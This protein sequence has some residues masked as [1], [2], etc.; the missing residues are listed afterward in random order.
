[1]GVK[2]SNNAKTTLSASV[3]TSATSVSV[4]S[5]SGFPSLS[6]GDYFYATMVQQSDDTALEIVKVTAVSGTT[7]TVSRAQDNTSATAFASGDKIELRASAGVFIDLFAEKAPIANPT[8]TGNLTIGSAEIS[9]TELEIL[10][11]AT[12]TTAELNKLDGTTATAA[13]LTYGKDLYDTGVTAAE[14]DYLDGV[15]SNIQTQISTKL[16]TPSGFARGSVIIGDSSGNPANLS[17]GANG[18]VLKS[19]GTDVTWAEDEK[20]TTTNFVKNAFTGDNTTTAFTLSQSPNSEDNL[21]VFIEGVFQ[22]QGDYALSGTTLT[23]DEAPATGRKIVAYHV[24]AAVSGANLNHDQFTA[25]GSAAFTLSI[26]PINENNTQVFIDGVYQQ[27]TDYSVSGTTL[28][29]DTAPASGAIVEVMT[30]TQTEI[31]V[32]TTGSVVTASIANDVNLN[33]NPT[34][35]TQSA[36]NNTTRIATTAFVETAVSN[37]IDSAPGTMNTLNEIAAALGDD[38][39]FTTTVN[40]AIAT[41]LPLAGGTMTGNL[42]VGGSGF[43]TT[44]INSTRTS[45]NIGGINFSA[46]GTNKAQIYGT[47]DGQLKLGTGGDGT[48]DSNL[49]LTLD[50]AGKVG[51]GTASP[52]QLLHV[53]GHA[54]ITSAY[55]LMFGDGGER[56]SGNNSTEILNFFTG[57]TERM[58]IDS[59]GKTLHT[60]ASQGSAFDASDNTTW[61]ALEIFQ[62]RGVT[63]SGSGI[64]FRSQSG[65]NP[66]G[67]VSVA[68]NTTGGIES[69][70]FITVAGN[71]GAERMRLHST[72]KLTVGSTPSASNGVIEANY[73]GNAFTLWLTTTA[74]NYLGFESTESGGQAWSFRTAGTGTYGSANGDL[75][76][77]NGTGGIFMRLDQS[78]ATVEGDFNDT[79]DIGLKKNIK[80]TTDGLA[81]LLKL[82]ARKFDWKDKDRRNN[83]NGFIAQ[84]VETVLPDEVIGDDYNEKKPE[85]GNKSINT[86]G[87]LAVAVKAIQEQQTIIDDLKARIETLEG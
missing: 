36:G 56:I 18:Y 4:A 34:T 72:G 58:R 42:V 54:A 45:G 11:G 79:S 60:V 86:S 55:S 85:H 41:K 37:L 48:V 1:V 3:S 52:S 35:T 14:F 81:E 6:G 17:A 24:K 9:E 27:K 64:A 12:V 50:T 61:N 73:T 53:D 46:S 5:S 84:E 26:T 40:N 87:L 43:T 13:S 62:D 63:N 82:K 76:F 33:G 57:A 22:N 16:T 47:V 68:G 78:A 2:F 67:I 39:S 59:S 38:P 29:F 8:F 80:D 25:S 70:A 15:T 19:D 66:A 44:T 31:N 74:Q 51:I 49:A 20:T 7:W 75:L 69:L 28:T 77:V 10:D 65:T 23:F 83:V 21:I 32:P 30:F 71:A